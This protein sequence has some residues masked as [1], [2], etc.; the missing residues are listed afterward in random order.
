M[1]KIEAVIFD[2]AGTTV[3]FG[4]F[5][6][7]QAFIKAFEEFGIT[8]TVDEVRAPM[9]MLKWNHIHTMM[10][11]P[12]I[13]KA[14]A[15]SHGRQWTREDVDAVYQKSES[16]IMEILHDFAQPKPYVLEAVKT[17]RE[18]GIQIG[19]TTGYTDEMMRIVVPEAERQGY[20]PDAWF[21]PDSVN[22]MGR[23]YPFMIFK[24]LEALRISSVSATIKV[25]D[26]TADIKEGKNAGLLSIGVIE[27]SSVM[28][29]SEAEYNVL[30][31]EE[32]RA[33][34]AQVTKIYQDCGADYVIDNMSS[35][36][37]LIDL[38][39]QQ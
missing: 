16:G 32:K 2:W 7:V 28:A 8:P 37:D 18:R 12:R 38:I 27:G 22:K 31:P 5:A 13:Q 35:L 15:I 24:N 11:M 33:C 39:Q 29:L 4:S 26:T 6:P 9:G 30:S 20:R 3:D 23:P 17:L 1:K 21:S 25:G 34:H 14:W 10:Q 36:P 19:S